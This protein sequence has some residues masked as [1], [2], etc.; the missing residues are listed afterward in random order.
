MT[1][2]NT[3]NNAPR[4]LLF[5]RKAARANLIIAGQGVF[6]FDNQESTVGCGFNLFNAD[7]SDGLNVA[8]TSSGVKVKQIANDD[9]F[10]DGNN[11][12]GLVDKSGVYYWFSVDSK[13]QRLIAGVGEARMET[14]IYAYQFTPVGSAKTLL[15]SLRSIELLPNSPVRMLRLL[16]D[17]VTW[18]VPL[19]VKAMEELTMDDIAEGHYMPKANLSAVSQQL[20]ECIGGSNF[21]LDTPEFPDFAK[22]IQHSIVTPGLWC[23]E[24]L[25]AKATEFTKEPNPAE[26]YLR[27]TLGMNNGESP[28]I[29][30]VMEIWPAG[31]YSPVHNHGGADAVIRV[32]HGEIRVSLFPYLSADSVGPFAVADFRSGDVTWISPTLNQVH[33]LHNVG[34]EACVTIQCYLYESNDTRHYDYFDYIDGDGSKKQYEPDSDMDFVAFKALMKTEWDTVTTVEEQHPVSSKRNW[35]CPNPFSAR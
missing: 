32:L 34:T 27:I 15:E 14:A 4:S 33:Q 10:D 21:Q 17:P 2:A 1:G 18:T 3:D 28:G 11:T 22:A 25:L 26:T 20:Y 23:Y 29:P 6:V 12:T 24:R 8:F 5:S 7:R 16:R 31:N 30:Y 13:N 19:Y 35:C 9:G